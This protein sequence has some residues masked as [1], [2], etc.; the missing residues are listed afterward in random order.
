MPGIP[1]ATGG[2]FQTAPQALEHAK[3]VHH[4]E[5]SYSL[6]ERT[7]SR[8]SFWYKLGWRDAALLPRLADFMLLAMLLV[9]N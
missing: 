8:M 7:V 2:P 5:C 1:C 4:T 3:P 6:I 9:G